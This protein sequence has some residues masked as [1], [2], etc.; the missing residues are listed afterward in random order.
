LLER[1]WLLT[2]EEFLRRN[3]G[4]SS[5][6]FEA[7]RDETASI[8]EEIAKFERQINNRVADLYGLTREEVNLVE[9]SSR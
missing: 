1:P 4:L 9:E 3:S 5:R 7:S 2:P 6:S 8:T